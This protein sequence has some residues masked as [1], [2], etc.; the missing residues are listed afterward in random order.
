MPMKQEWMSTD[1]NRDHYQTVK[2]VTTFRNT[3]KAGDAFE[4]CHEGPMLVKLFHFTLI[5]K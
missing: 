1:T 3:S 2:T 4:F 5:H